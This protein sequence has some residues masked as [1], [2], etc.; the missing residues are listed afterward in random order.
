MMN[1][2]RCTLGFAAVAAVVA[3]CAEGRLIVTVDLLSFVDQP[4]RSIPYDIPSGTQGSVQ[5]TVT[6]IEILEGV[7]GSTFIDSVRLSG[8]ADFVN[9]TG[10]GTFEFR[11]F[12]DT[13]P[14][15][16]ARPPAVVVQGSVTPAATTQITI[17]RELAAEFLPLFNRPTIYAAAEADFQSTDAPLTGPSLEGTL[18]LRRLLARIVAREGIF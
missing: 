3:A 4:D 12:L 6:E 15:P 10:S 13:L 14:L 7:G 17:D 8:S 9:A 1:W 18:E 11:I 16:F 2:A 5:S